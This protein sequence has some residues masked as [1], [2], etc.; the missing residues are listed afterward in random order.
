MVKGLSVAVA[1]S[2]TSTIVNINIKSKAQFFYESG[3]KKQVTGE[4]N[5][6]C[7][8]SFSAFFECI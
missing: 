6:L 7:I 4:N 2:V 3:T 5:L 1:K 8:Y